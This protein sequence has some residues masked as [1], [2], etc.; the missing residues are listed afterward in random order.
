[1]KHLK[2]TPLPRVS[3]AGGGGGGFTFTHINKFYS[4]QKRKMISR[5]VPPPSPPSPAVSTRCL[6]EMSNQ[7]R[8]AGAP[9]PLLSAASAPSLARRGGW[10]GGDLFCGDFSLCV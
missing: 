4:T 9:A 5:Q 1:M 2:M 3:R 6:L 10:G 8:P 7:F